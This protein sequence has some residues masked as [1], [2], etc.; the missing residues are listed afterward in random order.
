MLVAPVSRVSIVLG[1]V[2]GGASIATIQGLIFLAFW[3]VVGAWPGWGSMVA[4]GG[5]M[6]VLAMC[7]TAGSLC[8]AWPMDSTAGFHAVM[9]LLLMPMWF[10]SG[11]VFPLEAAPVGMQAMMWINPLTYGQA[12]FSTLL[13]G[14]EVGITAP[15]EVGTA[16][17]ALAGFTLGAVVLASWVVGRVGKGGAS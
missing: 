6:F 7:L 15:V 4:A 11:A 14:Q 1:K 17:G 13:R 9:N 16:L 5:V 2:L 8:L 10:L 3:P 12:A